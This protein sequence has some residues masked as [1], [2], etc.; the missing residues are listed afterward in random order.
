M[1]CVHVYRHRSLWAFTLQ[2]H[3]FTKIEDTVLY[4]IKISLLVSDI[5][6]KITLQKSLKTV[7]EQRD[8]KKKEKRRKWKD[9]GRELYA[10]KVHSFSRLFVFYPCYRG[11]CRLR[12]SIVRETGLLICA[13]WT[14]SWRAGKRCCIPLTFD[15]EGKGV[16]EEVE[17]A[18]FY[19]S[20]HP[21][22]S[23]I[24]SSLPNAPSDLANLQRHPRH[25]TCP[26]WNSR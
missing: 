26:W 14:E 7:G 13:L 24:C 23:S 25:Q 8:L 1:L 15:L 18:D 9:A 11:D 3:I 17:A 2:S 16:T 4:W 20:S 12:R 5:A 6:K 21:S 22:S 10:D 19:I